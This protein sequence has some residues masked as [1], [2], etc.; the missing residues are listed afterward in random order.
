[1]AKITRIQA[2]ELADRVIRHGKSDYFIV[3]SGKSVGLIEKGLEMYIGNIIPVGEQVLSKQAVRLVVD[4]N[5]FRHKDGRV[6]KGI[7]SDYIYKETNKVLHQMERDRELATQKERDRE[8]VK[9]VLREQEKVSRMSK[10]KGQ[11]LKV[12]KEDELEF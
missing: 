10:S 5:Y 4:V 1:M 2:D 7:L 11:R 8:L 9:Q 3:T 12:E 6:L